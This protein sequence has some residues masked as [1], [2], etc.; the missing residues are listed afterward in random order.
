M[1]EQQVEQQVEQQ[2]RSGHNVSKLRKESSN[3]HPE[4]LPETSDD[5]VGDYDIDDILLRTTTSKKVLKK[6][7]TASAE[8]TRSTWRWRQQRKVHQMRRN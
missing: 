3:S 4:Y 5:E 7:R 2:R 8:K 1:S 6:P